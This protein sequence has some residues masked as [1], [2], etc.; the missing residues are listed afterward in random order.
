M[1]N[2]IIG[3]EVNSNQ[4]KPKYLMNRQSHRKIITVDGSIEPKSAMIL[5]F[6]HQPNCPWGDFSG[7]QL[8]VVSSKRPLKK[9]PCS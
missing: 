7:Y 2:L 5:L 6:S 4:P 8:L 9:T 3:W 1:W